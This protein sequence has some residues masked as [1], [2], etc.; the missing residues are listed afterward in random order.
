MQIFDSNSSTTFYHNGRKYVKNF[1]VQKIG[2]TH[3]AVYNAYD[4]RLQLIHST[5]YSEVRV[6]G[7]FYNSQTALMSV[8]SPLCFSKGTNNEES[9]QN[10]QVK[11]FSLGEVEVLSTITA[12]DIADLVNSLNY[13]LTIND[14][15]T[16]VIVEAEAQGK[17]YLFLFT[18]GK[19][20]WGTYDGNTEIVH[21][22]YFQ[23]ISVIGEQN[24]V[25]K[26]VTYYFNG[27]G[28][29]T[30]AEVSTKINNSIFPLAVT[31]TTSPVIIEGVRINSSTK[32]MFLF[33]RGKGYYGFTLGS[34]IQSTTAS[35][36]KLISKLILTPEDVENDSNSLINYLGEV[37]DGQFISVANQSDWTF[38]GTSQQYYFSYN[39]NDILNFALF[40]GEPGLYG[41]SYTFFTESDF[42]IT[43]NSEVQPI[44]IPTLNEV[45]N[46]EADAIV[47][48]PI[49]MQSS[50]Y[51]GVTANGIN[52]NSL[53]AGITINGGAGGQITTN[54]ESGVSI[55]GN[56]G[57]VTINGYG[58]NIN[59]NGGGSGSLT[60]V[61]NGGLKVN[62]G[63]LY[64][65]NEAY[66]GVITDNTYPQSS[67]SNYIRINNGGNEMV[68]QAE[69]YSFFG[70][71]K[72][73]GLTNYYGD[74][75]FYSSGNGAIFYG[76]AGYYENLT[77]L[78]SGTSFVHKAYLERALSGFSTG[79]SVTV[80]DD[81]TSSA[82]SSALSAN[83]G[84][85]L[86]NSFNSVLKLSGGTLF[87][88]IVTQNVLP[89]A[90]N[91]YSLGGSVTNYYAN[92]FA[93][94]VRATNIQALAN[95]TSI[96]FKNYNNIQVGNAFNSGNWNLG[97]G[98]TDSGFRLNIDGTANV[99]GQLTS[100]TIIPNITNTY[101]LGSTTNYYSLGVIEQ[102]RGSIIQA[103]VN[104]T[105]I[106][107]RNSTGTVTATNFS[108]G[109]WNLGTGT[110]DQGVRLYVDGAQKN[111]GD[112]ELANIGNGIILRSP[113]GTRYRV[114]VANGGSLI[115]TAI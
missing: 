36:F 48:G 95:A 23:L 108:T 5:H 100:Q 33:T 115:T 93:T 51:F 35:D 56:A 34:D 90:N 63:I 10:N 24:N 43:T 106:Q 94:T 91:T 92:M 78:P 62:S 12:N 17:K 74:T 97:T 87:G 81:L 4:T 59:L 65:Q 64:N 99:N 19:G 67:Y 1:I 46:E 66:M 29:I 6:N 42:V 16:P 84:R 86:N 49:T 109:N 73:Y 61:N 38:T 68:M 20:I 32:Y 37:A 82:T 31:E 89:S 57:G 7:T 28:E 104:T 71:P 88:Q 58:G 77:S 70:N 8:L 13:N 85:I 110:T 60:V 76:N 72:F 98:T 52:L 103:R 114:A 69:S 11:Y 96:I 55:N 75:S 79:A 15:D 107:F 54:Q 26:V 45:M 102:L 80:I 40:V 113:D 47:D 2:D 83:Q 105:G 101:A 41:D 39:Q 53:N 50:A 18:Q 14:T 9:V 30:P 111:N 3:I 27:E 44:I 112:I 22:E 25:P 21:P